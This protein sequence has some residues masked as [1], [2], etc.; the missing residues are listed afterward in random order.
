MT[1]SL[2][3]VCVAMIS[4]VMSGSAA[5]QAVRATVLGTVSD[6]TGAVLLARP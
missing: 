6:R 1:R 4:L 2:L 5:A 3:V